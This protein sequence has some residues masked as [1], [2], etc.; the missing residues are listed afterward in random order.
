[1]SAPRCNHEPRR[2]LV[3]AANAKPQEQWVPYRNGATQLEGGE[4]L[5]AVHDTLRDRRLNPCTPA[6]AVANEEPLM[7]EPDARPY[8]AV[9]IERD[10]HGSSQPAMRLAVTG[11]LGKSFATSASGETGIEPLNC[12]S[13]E[14][15]SDAYRHQ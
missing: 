10:E 8:F 2:G 4:S 5:P 7:Y 11:R 9:T 1:M 15:C 12:R 13:V 6:L 14:A 3:K